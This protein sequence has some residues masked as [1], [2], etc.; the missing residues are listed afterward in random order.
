MSILGV[1]WQ[2][3]SNMLGWRYLDFEISLL[4][5]EGERLLPLL[6]EGQHIEDVAFY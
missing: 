2:F 3:R 4:F 6:D 1:G 5:F